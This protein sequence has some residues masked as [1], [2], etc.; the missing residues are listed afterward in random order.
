M[1]ENF[2]EA[3]GILGP[4][5]INT[6]AVPKKSEHTGGG[7]KFIINLDYSKIRKFCISKF[8]I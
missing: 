7:A 3:I 6:S 4:F 5:I 2:F 8:C 1:S